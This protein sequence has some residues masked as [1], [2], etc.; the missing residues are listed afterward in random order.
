MTFEIIKNT[1]P[2]PGARPRKGESKYPI[3]DMEVGDAFDF[4]LSHQGRRGEDRAANT[5]RS[6]I[7]KWR[8]TTGS[9]AAFSICKINETTGRCRRNT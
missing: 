2:L 6:I 9:R 8:K 3:A 7:S 4:P 5:L 1:P